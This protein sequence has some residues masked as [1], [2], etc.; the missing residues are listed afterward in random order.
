MISKETRLLAKTGLEVFVTNC[1]DL[2]LECGKNGDW[3]DATKYL[4][5]AIKAMQDAKTGKFA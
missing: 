5:E 2:A 3:E 4:H 1:I